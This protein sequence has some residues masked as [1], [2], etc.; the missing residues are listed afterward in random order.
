MNYMRRRL[1]IKRL[2]ILL[3]LFISIGFAYLSTNL[4]I[5]GILNAKGNT[6]NIYFDN[7]QV[8]EGSVELSQNDIYPT[9]SND[10]LT[11][12]YSVTLEM[13]G[14]YYEFTVDVVND[15]TLDAIIDF[16]NK[17][18]LNSPESDYL[19][20][21]ITYLNGESPFYS[22]YLDRNTTETYKVKIEYKRDIEEEYLPDSDQTV[23]LYFTCTYQKAEKHNYSE[24]C[25]SRD[26][27][28]KMIELAG[29]ASNIQKI[30]K[31]S[32]LSITPTE[33]IIVSADNS[34]YPIYMWYDNNSIFWYS[35]SDDV[36]LNGAYQLFKDFNNLTDISSISE[37]NTKNIDSL[38]D[39]FLG[40]T[41]LSDFS[42]ISGWDVSTAN[43]MTNMF[44]NCTSLTNVDFLSNW[45]TSN[46]RTIGEM[47]VGCTNL[48][49]INGISNWDTSYV[50]YVAYM[51][52]G[53]SSL[54]NVNA[55]KNW[56]TLNFQRMQGIF[57][58]CTSLSNI[59][60]LKDWNT[61]GCIYFQNA[62]EGCTS[63][64]DVSYLSNWDFSRLYNLDYMFSGCTNL[65]DVSA[66]NNWN[67]D[68]NNDP[69]VFNNTAVT[70]YP[71]WYTI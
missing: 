6:W 63:L 38:S 25:W 4:N 60:G 42:A 23:E 18:N 35:E 52:Q 14:D 9:I 13:P 51:F 47:F 59:S 48:T 16:K 28:E 65:S 29:N 15:G 57:K 34:K 1:N 20:F 41:S 5:N 22:D 17:T 53:C 24:F 62:F 64:T 39:M 55:L 32:S 11:V 54:T 12:N 21:T 8:S 46:V 19:D 67:I 31:A 3:I 33:D 10:K 69:G 71:T 36:R 61:S 56:N 45:D 7:I 44:E 30:K 37:W 43:H 66:L 49:N 27:N 70:T 2:F 58:D 40:C 26:L 50:T 68:E